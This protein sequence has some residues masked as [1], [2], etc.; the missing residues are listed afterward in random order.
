MGFTI[1]NWSPVHGQSNTT[2]NT[3]ALSILYSLEQQTRNLLTHTQLQYSSM[4]FLLNRNNKDT[5]FVS[6]GVK[7]IE[8]LMKSRLLKADSITDYTDTI[9]KNRLDLLGGSSEEIDGKLLQNVI[10][11]ASN[12]YDL[13]WV[14]AHSGLR[15]QTTKD[16]L[17]KANVIFIHLPH[18]QFILDEFFNENGGVPEII[19]NRPHVFI[20]SQ[21]N[22]NSSLNLKKI[23]RLY[24]LNNPVFG[25]PYSHSFKDAT[26]Q[27][28]VTEYLLKR[29]EIN[30]KH[31]DFEYI[32][33][34]K[35]IN[36]HL[37]KGIQMERE[38]VY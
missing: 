32:N 21:Y 11:V 20:I 8:R 37:Q 24:K 6:S 26:N 1:V 9:L 19:A 17:E 2:S 35:A 34:L 23:K 27:Q 14:D 38:R 13:I 29:S 10:E 25:I 4:E 33:S 7:A 5:T 18:N 36:Q 15:S 28:R 3:T 16:L 22:S 30:K 12:S 31:E